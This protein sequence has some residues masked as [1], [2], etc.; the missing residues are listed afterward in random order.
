MSEIYLAHHGI[1]G[2]RWGIRRYQNPDGSLTPAGLKRYG[3]QLRYDIDKSAKTAIKSKFKND[4]T[5]HSSDVNFK[6]AVK[7]LTDFADKTGE[8]Y[9]NV[10]NTAMEEA[11]NAMKNPKFKAAFEKNLK[12][13]LGDGF[14]DDELFEMSKQMAAEDALWD[15]CPKTKAAYESFKKD[16]D[17]YFGKVKKSAVELTKGYGDLPVS[18]FKKKDNIT[19]QKA[20]EKMLAN[21]SY[22]NQLSFLVNYD[23]RQFFDGIEVDTSSY[24]PEWYRKNLAKK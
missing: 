21:K 12:E 9:D 4:L 16:A 17:E 11:K 3:S 18:G 19:Y 23:Y 22:Y 5:P 10:I 15:N 20:V 24:T 6:K 7:D 1:K 8:G 2:Q 14:D 13:D